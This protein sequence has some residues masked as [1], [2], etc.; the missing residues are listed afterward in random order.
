M[1]RSDCVHN[2]LEIDAL[3]VRYR[4]EINMGFL[5]HP[6]IFGSAAALDSMGWGTR[7]GQEASINSPHLEAGV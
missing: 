1:T 2:L 4:T 5:R 7:G 3:Q 6:A